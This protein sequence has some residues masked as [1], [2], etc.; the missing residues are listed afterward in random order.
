[1]ATPTYSSPGIF[2][3]TDPWI[4]IGGTDIGMVAGAHGAADNNTTVLNGLVQLAQA[5]MAGACP[6]DTA[7]AATILI[8][9]HSNVPP[10]IGSGTDAGAEYFLRVP[11]SQVAPLYA[12]L[13]NC[14]WPIRFLGTGNVK[15]TLLINSNNEWGDMFYIQKNF[16]QDGDIGGITFEDLHLGYDH[17]NNHPATGS[18]IH[19]VAATSTGQGDGGQNVRIIRCVLSDCP[20]GVWFE[21]ALQPIIDDCTFVYTNNMATAAVMIGGQNNGFESP[22]CIE[23]HISHCTLRTSRSDGSTAMTIISAEHLRVENVRMDGFTNGIQI[24][25]KNSQN[26]VK[27]HFS[28]VSCY[29]GPGANNGPIGSSLTIQTDDTGGNPTNVS[30]MVFTAC[31][32]EPGD[33]NTFSTQTSGPGIQ[34]VQAANTYI[35]T[36]RF[37]SCYSCRFPGPGMSISGGSNIEVLGGMYAGNNLGSEPGGTPAN[38]PYGIY[39]TNVAGLRI[40]GA[41]CIGQYEQIIQ[42]SRNLSPQQTVGIY[43]D[44]GASGVIIANCDAR[45]SSSQGLYVNGGASDVII[46]AC[47]VRSNVTGAQGIVVNAATTAVTD[48]FIRDCNAKGFSS[49]STAISVSGS[50]SNVSTIQVTNCAGYND[51]GVNLTT[52]PPSS[53]TA[54]YNYTLATPYFGPISFV[55]W[56]GTGGA[57]ISEIDVNGHNTHQLLG[58]FS[59]PV[60]QSAAITWTPHMLSVISFVAI[61][62]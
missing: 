29:V 51:Q 32:F 33:T 35:D 18:A 47:G 16:G 44:N 24:V 5:Y 14:N 25:P 23:G 13:V 10:P 8:P 4:N 30:Q 19:T 55:T 7:H 38:Q 49:Y 2:V 37:I 57:T 58:A 42:S 3:A 46:E 28:D 27:C 26:V 21:Q 45:N 54:F 15:L 56:N 1:M 34:I 22:S 12:I 20:T 31:T 48:I 53:G 41:S 36:I 61:G 11:A 39:A 60:G 62:A 52:T 50:S 9:G 40:V 6:T 43:L 59:V 17:N